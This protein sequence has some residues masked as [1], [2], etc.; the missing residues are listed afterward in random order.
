MQTTAPAHVNRL[1]RET[2]PYLLQHAHNPVDWF[3]WG[4]EAFAEAKKRGVPVFLSVGYSTCYWCHV[5]ERQCFEVEAIAK[6]MNGRFVSVKVDRE[7]RPDVDSLYMTAVQLLTQGGGWPMSVF[8]TPDGRPFY[9]GTYFP[10]E[11]AHGRPGFPRV[12]N[13]MADAYADQRAEVEKNAEQLTAVLRR[14]ANPPRP[15]QKVTVDKALVATLVKQ[16]MAGFDLNHGGFGTAPKFPQETLLQLL[17]DA[18]TSAAVDDE[19]KA[20]IDLRL[21]LTLDAMANGGIRDQLGGGFHRY[22]TDAVWLVPHFEIMLYDQA[23]LGRVYAEASRLPN[24]VR[25][26]DVAR[27]VFDFV[28]RE[29]TSPAGAFYTAFDAEVDSREGQNYLWTRKQVEEVLGSKDGFEFDQLYGLDDGPNFADPHH[30]NGKPDSNILHLPDGPAGTDAPAIAAMRAKLLAARMKRKQPLLDTKIVTSWNALTIHGLAV[31]GKLLNEPRY[32]AAAARAAE[33]LL[34]THRDADGMIHRT[35]RDGA[36]SDHPG[37]LDDY[38]LLADALLA[39]HDATGAARWKTEASAV[40]R[41]MVARFADPAGGAFFFTG[42]S[43]GELIVRQKTAADSPLPSGN[44]VAATVEL[45]LGR[46]GVAQGVLRDFAATMAD[47]P[48]GAATML[49]AA[50]AYL[51][52]HGEFAVEPSTAAAKSDRPDSPAD[53]AAKTVQVRGEWADPTHL[54]IVLHVADGYHVN[55]HGAADPLIGTDLAVSGQHAADQTSVD[56][57]PGKPLNVAGIATTVYAGEVPI[58][59]TFARP[60]TE[61]VEL[62]LTFQ[63]CTDSACLPPV[64][65]TFTVRPFEKP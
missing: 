18:R 53:R 24:N 48:A 58:A 32:L 65:G 36:V 31:A 40:A 60:M 10:P 43:A 11:D 55:A 35:S 56:Y 61:A 42:K 45:A 6:V 1:I 57:P 14:L 64:T 34:G 16:S 25:Y 49:A 28:L 7:E 62:T 50:D 29:M 44:A 63:P 47:H 5:M 22:S 30:G 19:T 12:L 13:S 59:V 51:A 38:A 37:F 9:G 3:P 52:Q 33:Y 21:R 8:L 2:S 27:G 23:M 20:Q 17:L 46:P 15:E 26:A 41:Q 4:T 54:S 39:L